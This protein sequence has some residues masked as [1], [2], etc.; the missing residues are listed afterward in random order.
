MPRGDRTG[1][2]GEGPKT[3][4]QMGYCTGHQ[5]PGF[6]SMQKNWRGIGMGYGRGFGRGFGGGFG[7]GYRHGFGRIYEGIPD[8]SEK[9]LI[10]NEIS[11]LKD[12]LSSL[13]D[14]LSKLGEG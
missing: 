3:G 12:Q 9:T 11:I 6:A 2:F 10:E 8:V 14:R 7:Q 1:P 5:S 13:E 4:R